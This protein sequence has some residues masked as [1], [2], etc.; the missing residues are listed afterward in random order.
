MLYAYDVTTLL[1]HAVPDMVPRSQPPPQRI[2]ALTLLKL[3]FLILTPFLCSQRIVRRRMPHVI[4]HRYRNQNIALVLS[5]FIEDILYKYAPSMESYS[6][7]NTLERRVSQASLDHQHY[8]CNLL[9]GGNSWLACMLG[10]LYLW[11]S[12]VITSTS[13]LQPPENRHSAHQIHL[14]LCATL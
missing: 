9:S 2:P 6:N 8:L 12:F 1:V 11:C 4:R 3:S 5:I 10:L 7:Q 14:A 13:Y